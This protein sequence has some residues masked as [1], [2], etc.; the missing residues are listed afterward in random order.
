MDRA[1]Y[2]LT[3]GRPATG[4]KLT[5]R[6][7]PFWTTLWKPGARVGV[8]SGKTSLS[9]FSTWSAWLLTRIL[10]SPS[11][12]KASPRPP[13]SSE[14]IIFIRLSITRSPATTPISLPFCRTGAAMVMHRKLC[15]G[16]VR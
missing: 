13:A 1:R 11:T 8:W 9:D 3:E 16:A 5:S 12:R 15:G 2:H 6:A 10:P 14:V 7:L 4:V